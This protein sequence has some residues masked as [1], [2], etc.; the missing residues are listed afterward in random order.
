MPEHLK[1]LVD[2]VE[3][4]NKANIPICDFDYEDVQILWTLVNIHLEELG[5]VG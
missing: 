4:K 2:F 1:E 3:E 5:Y